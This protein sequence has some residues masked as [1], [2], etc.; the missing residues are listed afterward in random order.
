MQLT[1]CVH[2]PAGA[3]PLVI[4]LGG[5]GAIGI[6]CPGSKRRLRAASNRVAVQ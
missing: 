3:D 2:P 1:R 4:M 5:N 6:F